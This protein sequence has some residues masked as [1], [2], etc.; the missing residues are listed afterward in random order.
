MQNVASWHL[1]CFVI[2]AIRN[3][4]LL[5]GSIYLS[6]LTF[7]FYCHSNIKV[8]SL[9]EKY[10]QATVG[11]HEW[12]MSPE[13]ENVV[14]RDEYRE[15]KAV[16]VNDL[17]LYLWDGEVYKFCKCVWNTL[18]CIT[19]GYLRFDCF[20]LFIRI[21]MWNFRLFSFMPP[22]QSLHNPGRNS[23]LGF[24]W[25]ATWCSVRNQGSPS[26]SQSKRGIEILAR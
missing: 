15:I 7:F 21:R 4:V 24:T 22:T 18:T 14:I 17:L 20:A 23:T 10:L 9:T 11:W 13:L 8:S 19:T 6:F 1:P 5:G 16:T 3:F 26:K 25:P 2:T 12:P